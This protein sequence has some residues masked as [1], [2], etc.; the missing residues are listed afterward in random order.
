MINCI[1][2]EYSINIEKHKQCERA[3]ENIKDCKY[4]KNAHRGKSISI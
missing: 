3:D 1:D 4:F 2:C